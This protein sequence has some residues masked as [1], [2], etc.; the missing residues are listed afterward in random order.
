MAEI[1]VDFVR[2]ALGRY[3]WHQP[4]LVQVIDD[5]GDVWPFGIDEI[6]SDNDDVVIRI[7]VTGVI[8]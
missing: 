5:N 6:T 7:V 3:S 8:R 2:E 4:V 1:N